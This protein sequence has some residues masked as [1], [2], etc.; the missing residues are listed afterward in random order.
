MD[1]YI[2]IYIYI[3]FIHLD[4][5]ICNAYTW[6]YIDTLDNSYMMIY[7]YT[8]LSMHINFYIYTGTMGL[9][10]STTEDNS[11][12][13]VVTAK[14]IISQLQSKGL[15]ASIGIASGLAFCGLVGSSVRHEYA[16]MG[17][18]VNLSARLMSV[19]LVGTI[20]CDQK[21]KD[22]DRYV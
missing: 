7:F 14:S 3:Y 20:L 13:A 9:R 12:A 17:S 19:A 11:A 4:V 5:Y 15:N 10:G 18:S 1:L 2:Y 8:Y 22:S 6:L 16:V 21:T